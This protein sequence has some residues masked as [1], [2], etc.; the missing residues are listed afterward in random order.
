[1][2]FLTGRKTANTIVSP[3]FVVSAEYMGAVDASI[4]NIEKDGSILFSWKVNL[5][6]L[7]SIKDIIKSLFLLLSF[8]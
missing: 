6:V 8:P 7:S 4:L 1:M 2:L 3:V 5:K